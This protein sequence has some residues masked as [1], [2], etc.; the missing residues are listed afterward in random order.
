MNMLFYLQNKREKMKADV[1]EN[2][3]RIEYY[4]ERIMSGKEYID[5]VE[6]DIAELESIIALVERANLGVEVEDKTNDVVPF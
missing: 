2:L 4:K 1:I 6:L 5:K 3:S